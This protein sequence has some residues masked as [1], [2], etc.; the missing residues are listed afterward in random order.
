MVKIRPMDEAFILY[1]CLHGGPLTAES[2]GQQNPGDNKKWWDAMEDQG[3]FGLNDGFLRRIIAAYGSCAM[4]AWDG[5]MVV[6]DVRFFPKLLLERL[7]AESFCMQQAP[8]Y[9]VSKDFIDVPL[10]P[11]EKARNAPLR[12][13]CLMT[14]SPSQAEKPYQRRGIGSALVREL[15]KWA[16]ESGWPAIEALA[17]LDLPVIYEITGQA[18]RSFYEKLGFATVSERK[19][20]HVVG[21]FLKMLED[22][23]E[24]LGLSA[25]AA[26]TEYTMR[27]DLTSL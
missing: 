8:P 18:G 7:E 9:G 10:P 12:I 20:P 19:N 1:R 26:C 27:L 2:I 3:R 22:Q 4:L 25:E 21:D 17:F 24:K 14:G 16:K 15:I 11:L 23:A 5:D 6:G 13:N